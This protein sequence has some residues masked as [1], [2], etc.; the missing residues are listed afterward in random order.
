VAVHAGLLA[1]P[2]VV[3]KG[4]GGHG[5]DGDARIGAVQAA[6][7]LGG[8]EAVH[9]RHAQVHE[10]RRKFP[11]AAVGEG[12]HPG[13]A[14]FRGDHRQALVL[15][16]GHGDLAVQGV[17]LAK[18]DLAPGEVRI[19]GCRHRRLGPFFRGGVKVQAHREGGAGVLHAGHVDGAPHEVHQLLDDGEPQAR[20]HAFVAVAL[21]LGKGLVQ[22]GHELGVDADAVVLDHEQGVRFVTVLGVVVQVHVDV[23]A[24]G[25]VFDRVGQDVQEDLLD[26]QPVGQD[27]PGPGPA[28]VHG[29]GDVL[30]IRGLTDRVEE[31]REQGL[32]VHGFQVEGQLV[33]VDPGDGQGV[34]DQRPQQ[35]PRG[36]DLVQVVLERRRVRFPG[37]QGGEADD[38]VEGGAHVVADVGEELAALLGGAGHF[39]RP[40][41]FLLAPGH[42]VHDGEPFLLAPAQGDQQVDQEDD[43][44]RHH[45]QH[46]GEHGGGDAGQDGP[47]IGGVGLDAGGDDAVHILAG[48]VDALVQDA[49]EGGVSVGHGAAEA[50]GPGG[51]GGEGVGRGV[52]LVDEPVGCGQAADHRVHVAH[53]EGPEGLGHGVEG[54]VGELE[55]TA[56]GVLHQGLVPAGQPRRAHLAGAGPRP[57]HHDD[58]LGGEVLGQGQARGV[59]RGDPVAVNPQDVGLAGLHCRDGRLPGIVGGKGEGHAGLGADLL[60]K[61]GQD[62]RVRAVPGLGVKGLVVGQDGHRGGLVGLHPVFLRLGEGGVVRQAGEAVFFQQAG[63]VLGVEGEDLLHG[64]VH[65][66]LQGRLVLPVQVV[67]GSGGEGQEGAVPFLEG[68]TQKDGVHLAAVQ[69]GVQAVHP[70]VFD[71]GGGD[72]L[73]GAPVVEPAGGAAA[74]CDP[75]LHGRDG[76][77]VAV[78]IAIVIGPADEAGAAGALRG[79]AEQ[80]P[81][82]P[83]AGFG[84]VTG[85][86][87]AAGIQVRQHGSGVGIGDHLHQNAGLLCDVF[88][89]FHVGAAPMALGVLVAIAGVFKDTD[90]DGLDGGRV[91]R[92]GGAGRPDNHEQYHQCR[93][94]HTPS[95]C[96]PHPMSPF[97]QTASGPGPPGMPRPAERRAIPFD[98]F[99]YTYEYDIRFC[100]EKQR[101]KD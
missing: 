25:R 60:I 19:R 58:A 45:R 14:V 16:Q 76:L 67:I 94:S 30:F 52:G 77:D 95:P 63:L 18:E 29:E 65:A 12:F 35:V 74:G 66:D 13:L 59:G 20:A 7:G 22:M 73:G 40:D 2:H 87:D 62:A 21:F 26:S 88:S 27:G 43:H 49:L 39:F 75:D 38:G 55:L 97:R 96:A 54:L 51:D 90:P 10:H 17:V 64:R 48:G 1:A 32:A 72:A 33:A 84:E 101:Y 61:G 80:V 3:V 15:E 8:V 44:G 36:L 23:A 24:L 9:H 98:S 89:L 46:A 78:F 57:G 31:G 50:D 42:L 91:R 47:G 83:V 6:D 69:G 4:V 68:G 71:G 93:Q 37:R 56:Q 53:L 70:G 100:R 79:F 11:G 5:Q 92:V 85:D 34:I 99:E 28:G 86:V 41:G 81:G 82:L